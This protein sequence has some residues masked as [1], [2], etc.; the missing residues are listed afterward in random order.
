MEHVQAIL[1]KVSADLGSVANGD[2]VIGSPV[3][4]GSVTVYPISRISVG[5]G[6]G[7]GKGENEAGVD[8]KG[9]KSH[10]AGTG[11]GSGGGAKAVPVAVLVFSPEGVSVLPIP[12]KKGKLDR[13]LEKLPGLV[14]RIK[15][16]VE[17]AS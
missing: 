4:L 15:A 6:A 16:H 5:L 2:A 10:E 17:S 3:K 7:G 8:D 13:L 9:E 1:E 14:E 11:G 12:H